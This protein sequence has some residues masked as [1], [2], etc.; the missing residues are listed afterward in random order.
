MEGSIYGEL[1]RSQDMMDYMLFP[2][3]LG[4]AERA[5]HKGV[6]EDMEEDNKRK[7]AMNDDWQR[8]ARIVGSKEL[9]RLDDLGVMYRIS[10]AGAK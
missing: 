5:W 2:R 10:P 9:K 4:L 3:L 8:F 6:W 1:I 7:I